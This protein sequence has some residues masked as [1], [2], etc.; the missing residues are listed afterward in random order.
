MTAGK[1]KLKI[2]AIVQARMGSTRFPGK[3]LMDIGGSP[4]VWQVLNRLQFSDKLTD[5]ILA[6]SDTEENN[7]LD[8]FAQENKVNYLRGSEQDVLNRYYEA[9]KEFKIDVIVRVTA[10]CPL[11]DPKI[12][13]L[14]IGKHLISGADYTSNNLKKRTLPLGLDVEVFNFS[15]LEKAEKEAVKDFDR[16]HVVPYIWQHPEIFKLQHVEGKGKIKRPELNLTVDTKE[17]LELVRKIYQHLYNP[18]KIFYTKEI[19]DLL[20]THL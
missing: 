9:A 11:I 12:I 19:I 1:K 17:D 13:D 16:E 6:I 20:D 2:G 14:V 4:M 15:V 10:D 3:V 7:V 18:P 8:N 5:I